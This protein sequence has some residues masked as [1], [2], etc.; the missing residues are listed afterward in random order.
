VEPFAKGPVRGAGGNATNAVTPVSGLRLVR[1]VLQ[2]FER[3]DFTLWFRSRPLRFAYFE[4]LI[5]CNIA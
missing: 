3:L 5:R 4:E 2:A 1:V